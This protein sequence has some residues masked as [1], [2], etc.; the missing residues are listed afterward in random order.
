VRLIGRS[1]KECHQDQLYKG[2]YSPFKII[3]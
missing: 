3:K 1:V 2:V